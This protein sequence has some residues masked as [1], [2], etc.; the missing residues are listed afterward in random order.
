MKLSTTL[1]FSALFLAVAGFYIYLNPSSP[2]PLKTSSDPASRLVLPVA[3]KNGRV[4]LQIQKIASDETITL[5]R[6]TEGQ[7]VLR[8]PV[9]YPADNM[10]AE[11]LFT[12]LR[13]SAKARRFVR[14]RGWEEYGLLKPALKIGVEMPP[15]KRRYLALGDVSPTA[16]LVY[17][18]WEGEE[19]YFL[20]DENLKKAMERSVYSLRRKNVFTLAPAEISRIQ[21]R[22]AGK[23]YEFYKKEGLWVWTKPLALL[24]QAVP[25][26]P[27]QSFEEAALG[28]YVKNFLDEEDP[29]QF[30]LSGGGNSIEISNEKKIET[31]ELGSETPEQDAC[32]A[33]KKNENVLLQVARSRVQSVF[34]QAE[35][36]LAAPKSK[37]A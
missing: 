15:Q 26:G 7:W 17:A 8:H 32:Y 19:E 6:N 29:S 14:D 25:A 35:A 34:A 21:I 28:L 18:R 31:L 1:A 9:N 5:E 22:Q 24:G 13:L 3:D 27:F 10:M 4:I 12:A 36:L 11:G 23:G 2:A 20:V 37:A 30:D 33:R 16:R